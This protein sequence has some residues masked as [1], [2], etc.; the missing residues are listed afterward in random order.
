MLARAMCNRRGSIA[1][2]REAEPDLERGLSPKTV[3]TSA[4]RK[5]F[6][7]RNHYGFDA[8]AASVNTRPG[9]MHGRFCGN[10][11]Y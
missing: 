7:S 1:D 8:D 6:V 3:G 4:N 11:R 9:I 2:W 10:A 5:T